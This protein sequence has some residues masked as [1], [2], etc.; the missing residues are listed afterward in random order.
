M[1]SPPIRRSRRSSPARIKGGIL[2]RR[3]NQSASTGAATLRLLCRHLV[4]ARGNWK[5]NKAFHTWL[6]AK[7][8]G[9]DALEPI[10]IEYAA[11]IA[12]G[13][14]TTTAEEASVRPRSADLCYTFT[15]GISGLHFP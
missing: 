7:N 1:N 8:L 4:E 2:G 12:M 6:I 11:A 9:E 13:E 3:E 15:P 10:R 5:L 14:D